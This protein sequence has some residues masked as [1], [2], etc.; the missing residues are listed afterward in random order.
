MTLEKWI[1]DNYNHLQLTTKN[2]VKNEDA[3]DVFQSVIEQLL[4]K[5][6]KLE[7]MTDKEKLYFFIRVVKNNYFSK[8]SVYFREHKK[9][10]QYF[11]ELTDYY[12]NSPDTEY[13][14]DIPDIEWVKNELLNFNWFERDLFLLW[15]ELG[16]LANVSKST[17]IPV[18][19]VARYIK[20]IK[21]K[22]LEKW[23][24]R[25]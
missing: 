25:N 3:D 22:L 8:T 21:T 24:N 11:T 19:S 23:E 2:I 1:K 6:E 5:K 12:L 13:T 20:Q 14:E 18:N 17:T 10:S 7:G 15:Y 16:T 9:G 4:K